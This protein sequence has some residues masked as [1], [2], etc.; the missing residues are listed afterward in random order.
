MQL[1]YIEVAHKDYDDTGYGFS[2]HSILARREDGLRW[3]ME[4]AGFRWI[5]NE[6]GYHVSTWFGSLP[7]ARDFWNENFESSSAV[8]VDEFFSSLK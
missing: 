5:G 3:K 2:G 4:R 1:R 8:T 6:G 7:E